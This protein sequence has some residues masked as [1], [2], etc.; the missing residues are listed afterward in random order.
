MKY[1]LLLVSFMNLSYAGESV[2]VGNGGGVLF[3]ESREPVILDIYESEFAEIHTFEN[4][5]SLTLKQRSQ[6]L[7]NRIAT[8][9]PR[10]KKLFEELR[11]FFHQKSRFVETDSLII[12]DDFENLFYENICQLKVVVVQRRPILKFD[13]VFFLHSELW[14]MSGKMTQQALIDHEILYMLAI[15]AGK[16]NSQSTREFLAYILSDSYFKSTESELKTF[17]LKSIFPDYSLSTTYSM[18]SIT[19]QFYYSKLCSTL[20]KKYFFTCPE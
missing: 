11:V 7:A 14:E 18:G 1:I 8:F 3:C 6:L 13:K 2:R 9:A 5:K 17:F 10:Y 12:P 19:D 4:L 20:K 16:K 15:I